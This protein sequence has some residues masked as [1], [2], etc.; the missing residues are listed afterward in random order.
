MKMEQQ[1][2]EKQ[3]DRAE[4]SD[5]NRRT[6]K[7]QKRGKSQN[8]VETA[9]AGYKISRNSPKKSQKRKTGKREAYKTGETHDI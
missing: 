3:E 1:K 7:E 2:G 4:V 6:M 8:T 5:E 9:N